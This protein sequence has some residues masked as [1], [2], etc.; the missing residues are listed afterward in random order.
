MIAQSVAT[1]AIMVASEGAIIPDPLLMQVS[2]TSL[3][4]MAT[5]RLASLTRVSVVMI[6]SAAAMASGLSE[7]ES[8]GI[9][10]TILCAG[11]RTPMT[12]VDA[13]STALAGIRSC[14]AAA[15]QTVLTSSSPSG[16]VS[17]LALPL[18]ITTARSCSAGRRFSASRTGAALARFC[19]KQPAAEQGVSLYTSARS[20]R[21]GLM[22]AWMP[23]QR[24][25]FASFKDGTPA[26]CRGRPSPASPS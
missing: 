1:T 3:P 2:V 10:A 20:L 17:A 21:F 15:S 23:A 13:V 6:A 24:N 8:A 12:P 25:P 26:R 11:S 9:A 5:V 22:P 7:A 19:V 16:P 4:P 18:L 14:L